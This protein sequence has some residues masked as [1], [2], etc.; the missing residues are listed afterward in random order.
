MKIITYNH[1]FI[2]GF[3][4]L[5]TELVWVRMNSLAAN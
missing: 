2:P 5:E 4:K 1:N 3:Y